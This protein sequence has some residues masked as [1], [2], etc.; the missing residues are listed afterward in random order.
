VFLAPEGIHCIHTADQGQEMDGEGCL[1]RLATNCVLQS[2]RTHQPSC[3]CHSRDVTKYIIVAGR[4]LRCVCSADDEDKIQSQADRCSP[5]FLQLIPAIGL[6]LFGEPE[7]EV[8]RVEVALETLR[9]R[10]PS[11]E[12]RHIVDRDNSRENSLGISPD[13]LLDLVSGTSREIS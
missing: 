12:L 10:L 5:F 9:E 6:K 3:P 7:E 2:P 8:V 13:G 4:P 1:Q 11:Y